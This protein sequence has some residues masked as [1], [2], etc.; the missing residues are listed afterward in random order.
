MTIEKTD[1]SAAT[2]E[3]VKAGDDKSYISTAYKL[4]QQKV[5]SITKDKK[6]QEIII[7]K[8][9]QQSIDA[10]VTQRFFDD[11]YEILYTKDQ[12]AR[13]PFLNLGPGSF[14]HKMWRTA[15]KNYGEDNTAWTKMRRGKEQPPVDYYWDV[16]EGV[17]LAE[18]DGF[19]EVIY[20]S[21][22]I[23]HLFPADAAFL[24]REARRLLAPGGTFRI[25]CPDAALMM[26]AYESEDWTYFFHY[27]IVKTK[28]F[29]KPIS[30][31]SQEDLK[32]VCAEFMIEWVSL[33]T[34]KQNPKRL[35]RKECVAFI[36]SYPN[37]KD[38]F[39]AAC[40][41]SSRELNKEIGGHV[42]WFD[43]PKLVDLLGRAG[44]GNI[45]ISGYLQS[46]APILRDLRYFDRT[47]PEMSIFVDASL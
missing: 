43:A 7:R 22:V 5:S 13:R 4:L 41:M 40:E 26:R 23:E 33:L 11:I 37:L 39:D 18:E 27:L 2:K 6:Q 8:A 21:H 29:A 14:R 30:R 42:N 16:Y 35:D 12:L 31:L 38:A 28:R 46:D 36:D 44:F 20:C 32:Q 10:K 24:C 3:P 19:F 1:T 45:K 15:D 9:A 25:V 34:N 47:D 17:P